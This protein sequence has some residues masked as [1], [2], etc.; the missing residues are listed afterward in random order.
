MCHGAPHR[1]TWFPQSGP[2]EP[3]PY[4]K[5]GYIGCGC[6]RGR[7]IAGDPAPVPASSRANFQVARASS[8]NLKVWRSL[9]LWCCARVEGCT[10]VAGFTSCSLRSTARKHASSNGQGEALNV[11]EP[12]GRRGSRGSI[13]R[14]SMRASRA[15]D[16]G[17]NP[18]R[19]STRG[20]TR[21]M[22]YSRRSLRPPRGHPP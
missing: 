4:L 15:R 18:G 9:G 3:D 22:L 10:F 12:E 8:H 5:R 19:G 13:A 11:L 7:R 17:S 21:A 20:L 2:A 14:P 6:R 16:P 1:P